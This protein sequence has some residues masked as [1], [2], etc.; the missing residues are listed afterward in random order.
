MLEEQAVG[1]RGYWQLLQHKK[2]RKRERFLLGIPS[3]LDN[4]KIPGNSSRN[5]ER[6]KRQK[7]T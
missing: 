7:K 4:N 3:V 5:P 2:L 6:E 1:R